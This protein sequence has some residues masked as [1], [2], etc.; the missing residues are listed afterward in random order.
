MPGVHIE[1]AGQEDAEAILA[2]QKLAYLSEARIYD[3]WNLPPIT[4]SLDSVREE[5]A[6]SVVLKALEGG[7][8]AGSVRARED[9]GTCHIGRLVVAPPLQ[10]RGI[11][12]RLMLEIE[13]WF[14]RVP[15]FELFTGGRSEA[16]LRLYQRLGYRPCREQVL[17]PVVTLVYLEKL[18]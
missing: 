6:T 13:A 11:G 16:N 14:P 10:R 18:R 2:L 17:T 1:R 8:L 9:S 4:Q 12:T 7:Q 15:R 5:F 3:D